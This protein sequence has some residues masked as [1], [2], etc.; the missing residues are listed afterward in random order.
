[1][2]QHLNS[3]VDLFTKA[4]KENNA[5][6]FAGAGLSIPAGFVNWKNLLREIAA[7]LNL[8][9]DKENDLIAI[10]QY[11][12]CQKPDYSPCPGSHYSPP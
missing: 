12:Y 9:I 11:H 10:A 4:I 3:F 8:D 6:I 2:E 1:M 7:E 5:A